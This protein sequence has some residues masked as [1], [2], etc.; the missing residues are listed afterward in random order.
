[1]KTL[2]RREGSVLKDLILTGKMSIHLSLVYVHT[3][4]VDVEIS[5][6]LLPECLAKWV[7]QG[8]ENNQ[9]VV[10]AASLFEQRPIKG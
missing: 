7:G 8:L 3:H 2:G 9:D 10:N 1:M 5:F 6:Y 4:C